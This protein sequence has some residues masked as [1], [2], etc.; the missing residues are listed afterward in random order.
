MSCLFLHLY[1]VSVSIMVSNRLLLIG[2]Y[3]YATGIKRCGFWARV[4]CLAPVLKLFLPVLI[5][6]SYALE[7]SGRP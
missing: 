6:G 7:F 4:F 5:V 3:R 2:V 1:G